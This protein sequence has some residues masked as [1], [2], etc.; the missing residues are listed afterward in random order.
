MIKKIVIAFKQKKFLLKA[1]ILSTIFLM[2]MVYI[3]GISVLVVQ[4]MRLDELWRF[5][6]IPVSLFFIWTQRAVFSNLQ[7][8]T[9]FFT[10]ALLIAIGSVAYILWKI[11]FIDL[12]IETSLF[13]SQ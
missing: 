3:D 5:L 12:C 6:I 7:L 9:S 10:G 11:S 4:W 13:F 1:C 2:G 8:N